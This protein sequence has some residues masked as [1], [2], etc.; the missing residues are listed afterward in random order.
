[1]N[2]CIKPSKLNGK[3]AAIGSKSEM[4]RFLIASALCNEPTKININTT[5]VD[6]ET[7]R[8]CLK[9]MFEKTPETKINV[10]ESGSTFRFLLPLAAS[11]DKAVE[12][13]GEG[14][15]G[16]RPISAL[17]DELRRNGALIAG[18]KLPL[19]CSGGLRGGRFVFRGDES[20]QYISGM[21]FVAPLLKEESEIIIEGELQSVNYVD[22]TVDVLQK[23]GITIRKT[24]DGYFIRGGQKYRSPGEITV[25]GDWSNAAFFIAANY[26][27]GNVE[28][29]GLDNNSLQGDKEILKILSLFKNAK[30]DITIDVSNIPDL[31]P[32][33]A[34]MACNCPY[35][36]NIV[37][38]ARL[39]LKESDRLLST[40]ECLKKLGARVEVFDDSLKIYGGAKIHGGTVDSFNDHRIVMSMTMLSLL[41]QQDIIIENAEA[42]K[43]SY[44]NFFEDFRALGG[45][46]N[47]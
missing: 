40:S 20:S 41:S 36:T 43:K 11:L 9:K 30:S 44:M 18:D 14:R 16:E 32:I 42:A 47:V 24:D 28:V 25:G 29:L 45:K 19:T 10:K 3:I 5:S 17:L 26:L 15:L 1:M 13:V 39:K 35:N 38:A 12:F 7:T 33:M 27:G 23:F 31:V 21:M 34:V 37:N 2:V 46:V 6:I 4:H 8:E 22:I